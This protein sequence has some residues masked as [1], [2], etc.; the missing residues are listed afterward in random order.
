MSIAKIVLSVE[1]TNQTGNKM[2]NKRGGR[3]GWKKQNMT[4][5]QEEP[6]TNRNFKNS[7]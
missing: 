4:L 2:S 6:G 3:G 5:S 7:Q 1:K